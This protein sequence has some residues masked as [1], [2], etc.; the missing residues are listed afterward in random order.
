MATSFSK[1]TS[2]ITVDC[3]LR[4][5][6]VAGI[7]A[8]MPAQ[9]SLPDLFSAQ[10]RAE[11]SAAAA[12]KGAI[13]ANEQSPGPRHL[14]PKDLAGSLKRLTDDE[15]DALLSATTLEAERRGR[16]PLSGAKGKASAANPKA[17]RTPVE[18]IAGRLTTGKL[19][20]IR[21]AFKAGVRPS[22]IARQF[23][24]SQADIRKALATK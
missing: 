13:A 5:R 9:R 18:E 22:A 1:K 15:I 4:S 20:A 7:V 24:L 16:L 11:T 23:G 17:G 6:S 14:L 3:R 10:P 8:R 12:D 21:A 19:N 2:G